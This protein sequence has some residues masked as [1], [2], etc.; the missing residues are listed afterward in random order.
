MRTGR[1][2]GGGEPVSEPAAGSPESGAAG[3]GGT[4]PSRWKGALTALLLLVT[5]AVLGVAVD[6]LWLGAPPEAEAAPLTV[7]A[8]ARS[9]DLAPADRVRVRRLLDSLEVEVAEAARSGPDSLRSVARRARIRLEGALPP[10]ARLEFRRWMQSQHRRMMER[11]HGPGAGPVRP[12]GMGPMHR[13]GGG[14]MEPD[15]GMMR[16]GGERPMRP[17]A[18]PRRR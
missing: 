13:Q 14:M 7:D 6:R 9:L 16:P 10:G 11:M 2:K 1:S 8:M 4:T 17:D 5:G 12:D 18:P 3:V 15:G